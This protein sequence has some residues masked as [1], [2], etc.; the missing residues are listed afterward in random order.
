MHEMLK[1]YVLKRVEEKYEEKC[2]LILKKKLQKECE[3]YV[4]DKQEN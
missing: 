2:E 3:Q 4:R 1:I